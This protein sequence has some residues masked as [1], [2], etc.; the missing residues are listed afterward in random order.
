M[1]ILHSPFAI[2]IYPDNITSCHGIIFTTIG[3]YVAVFLIETFLND[4]PFL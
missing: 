4:I 3:L 2:F 1:Y